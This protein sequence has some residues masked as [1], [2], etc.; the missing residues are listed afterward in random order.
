MSKTISDWI[1]ELS[2]S[3]KNTSKE[4][5][6]ALS[7]MG[8]AAVDPLLETLQ[9]NR[10]DLKL[11]ASI[12]GQIGEP[13]LDSI[14]LLLQGND[15]YLRE[16]AASLFALIADTRSVLPLVMAL[17]DVEPSVRAGIAKALGSFSDPRAVSALIDTL[18]DGDA[19]VRASAAESLGSYYRDP[20][21][22]PALI[23]SADDSSP[24]VRVGTAKAMAKVHNERIKAK[25]QTMTSDED[26][27]VRLTAAAALQHQGGDRMVFER[28][29]V[30]VSD[31]VD[32]IAQEMLEDDVLDEQDIDLMRNSNPRIRAQ[33][34]ER[35]GESHSEAA[36][37]LI[38]PGLNDI[39]P[40]VR[41]TAV[42]IL[43]RMGAN[44]TEALIEALMDESKYVRAGV[45]EA[46]AVIS[47][48]TSIEA[49][50]ERLQ[51]DDAEQVRREAA[52]ALGQFEA[53]DPIIKSLKHALKDTDKDVQATAQQSLI[54]LGA[55]TSNPVSRFFRRFTGNE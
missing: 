8:G 13:A 53:N 51:N 28:M 18:A 11:I 5:S 37:K 47:N 27:D 41:Q 9:D 10:V 52:R 35:V 12:L 26:S 39:N 32:A 43:I 25:L 42:E 48:P 46:L 44:A 34:L 23:R 17:E 50:C 4:A 24:Q 31:K 54:Q 21:V 36:V 1:D 49:L 33:L 16:Q 22:I 15:R 6:R 45:I 38:L 3:D 2:S 40:A 29:N 19:N 55:D 7:Y 14:G 20:R 30:D